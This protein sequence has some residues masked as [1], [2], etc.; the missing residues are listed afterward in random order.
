MEFR[1][2][3]R[4]DLPTFTNVI[5]LGIGKLERSTGLDQSAEAMFAM[6]SRWSI[7]LLLGLSRLI[8][9][10]FVRVY[11]AVHGTRV[12][13]TG[14]V[15]MLSR[16]G[17]VGGMATETEYR[18]RGIASRILALQQVETARR[19]R[20]WLVLDV[21][22][23][24]DTAIRVYQRAGYR[25][26]GRFAWFTR[27]GLPATIVP[28][29]TETRVASIREIEELAPQLDRNRSADYRAALPATERM[30]SHN[31]VLVRGI[32]GQHQTWVQRAPNG[33]LSAVRAYYIP[34]TEMG[35]YFP[36]AGP[37]EPEPETLARSFDPAT[38]WLRAHTPRSCL[39][40]VPEP[41]GAVGAA[42]VRLG[43]T[44]VVSTMTM[45]RP[46]SR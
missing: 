25:E 41:V 12:V 46:S 11:V 39:A 27:P 28:L 44:E 30:L 35:V 40:I 21:E 3:R 9:R 45:A 36:L 33:S 4:A 19:G 23:E 2:L 5:R 18:G 38:E 7:W 22:S 17:Y 15:F 20:D 6:M 42:L 26:V 37:P 32:R 13:G 14:T 10:P 8:G 1:Q 29:P 31:E 43:F 24:N 16:A 34:R